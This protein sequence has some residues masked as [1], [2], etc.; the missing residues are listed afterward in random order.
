MCTMAEKMPQPASSLDSQRLSVS[1]PRPQGDFAAFR[2]IE[3]FPDRASFSL[4]SEW[5]PP[6]PLVIVKSGERLIFLAL[7]RLISIRIVLIA[8]VA[9]YRRRQGLL[10]RLAG[11]DSPVLSRMQ[12]IWMSNVI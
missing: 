12:H 2:S 10:W 6:F 11:D 9:H 5:P 4:Q 1:P 3:R 8:A 7:E